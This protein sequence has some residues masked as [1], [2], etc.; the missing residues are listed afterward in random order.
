[1]SKYKYKFTLHQIYN[2]YA[3]HCSLNWRELAV[4]A[5]ASTRTLQK[6]FG[7]TDEL[8]L[9][10]SDYHLSYLENYYSNYR[11]TK[12]DDLNEQ[13]RFV[14]TVVKRHQSSYQ[15]TEN[16]RRTNLSGKGKEI[17]EKHLNYIR[18]A[19][20][21]GGVNK[22]KIFPEMVFSFLLNPIPDGKPGNDLL[23]HWMKWFMV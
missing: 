11:V 6:Y 13:F 16:A 21:H 17:K 18:N 15:F 2:H 14:R 22:E 4:A 7:S 12:R 19:M 1:M 3:F 8:S 20:D 23:F 9:T 10:L 5:N